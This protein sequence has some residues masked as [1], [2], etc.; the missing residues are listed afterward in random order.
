VSKAD[1]IIHLEEAKRVLCLEAYRGSHLDDMQPV[2]DFTIAEELER[3][4]SAL[5]PRG[6]SMFA[7]LADSIR[8]A[9]VEI[10]AALNALKDQQP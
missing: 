7:P 9:Y 8:T 4:D 6:K 1:A 2:C 3:I 10:S 5:G